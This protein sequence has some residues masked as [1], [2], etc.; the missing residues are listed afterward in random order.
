VYLLKS[1]DEAFSHFEIYKAKSE[2]QLDRKIK[3]FRSDRGGEYFSNNF[4]SFYA[5][6]GIL[7]M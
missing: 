4:D 1:K 3:R 5:E 7:S 2:N 6:H